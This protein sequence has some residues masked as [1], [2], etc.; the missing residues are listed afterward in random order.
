MDPEVR[1]FSI[2]CSLLNVA[3]GGGGSGWPLTSSSKVS[4]SPSASMSGIPSAS[5][6]ESICSSS[7]SSSSSCGCLRF[8][9]GG[10]GEPAAEL[11]MG[12]GEAAAEAALMV[13][14]FKSDC[15][16][17]VFPSIFCVTEGGFFPGGGFGRGHSISRLRTSRD[18]STH[19]SK[20]LLN[21]SQCT[22]YSN[23]SSGLLLLSS[24]FSAFRVRRVATDGCDCC[25]LSRMERISAN[26]SSISPLGPG[27]WM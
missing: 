2:S 23:W 14:F 10:A 9:E 25:G 22:K 6:S 11:S 19:W 3:S 15:G 8:R 7:S 4:G 12:V 13:A 1:S 27:R 5:W 17:G 18:P 16:R 26:R 24:S 20:R 21:V